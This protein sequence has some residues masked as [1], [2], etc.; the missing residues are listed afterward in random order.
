MEAFVTRRDLIAVGVDG[1]GHIWK[2]H[3]GMAPEYHLFDRAG[4]LVE[5]RANPHGIGAG[6]RKDHSDPTL[7]MDL[8]PDCS[9]YIARRMGKQSQQRLI[10]LGVETVTTDEPD[11][12]VVLAAYLDAS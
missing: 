5:K 2:S 11:P 1:D 9:T 12:S 6:I 4:E 7:I 10:E 3:F 8:L